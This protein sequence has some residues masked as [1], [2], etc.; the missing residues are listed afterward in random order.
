MKIYEEIEESEGQILF[1]LFF[2]TLGI[3]ITNMFGTIFNWGINGVS[4]LVIKG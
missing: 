3:I 4:T 2:E 1:V